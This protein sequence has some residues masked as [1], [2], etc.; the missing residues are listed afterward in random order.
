MTFGD[1]LIELRR[2]ILYCVFAALGGMIVAYFMC[3][4]V[5]FPFVRAPIDAIE[6]RDA[7]NPFVV[8]TPWLDLLVEHYDEQVAEREAARRAA[9]RAASRVRVLLPLPLPPPVPQTVEIVV[10]VEPPQARRPPNQLYFR[11]PQTAFRTRLKLS[12]LAG[13]V[14]VLPVVAYQIWAFVA[15]GLRPQERRLVRVYGPVSF[16]LFVVGMAMAYVLILPVAVAFLLGQGAEMGAEPLLEINEVGPFVVW[17]MIGL[18][19]VF[20][21]PLVIL[22]L[23][24]ARIVTPDE[25]ARARPYAA[26]GIFVVAA[27][28]TPPDPFTQ[29]A[30]ALPMLMLFEGSLIVA[31]WTWR[32]RTA[33]A[34]H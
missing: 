31:R 15:H 10:R 23:T 32:S 28:L 13:L 5:I 22:F 21:T 3:P 9:E 12:L 24:R 1:H 14:L 18:G 30:V 26:V 20:E 7:E 34:R 33:R 6:G 11:N 4:D 29:I 25:L 8:R 2:R 19:I 27:V 16:G 17:V